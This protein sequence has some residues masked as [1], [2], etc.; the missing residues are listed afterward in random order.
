VFERLNAMHEVML[1][2][3]TPI[4]LLC[5]KQSQ[6]PYKNLHK[7]P[8]LKKQLPLIEAYIR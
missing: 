8:F 7:N 1:Y 3:K 2:Q 4:E 5:K 6:T